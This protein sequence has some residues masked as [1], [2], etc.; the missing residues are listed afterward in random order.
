MRRFVMTAAVLAL[1]V[2]RADAD[3][4]LTF[5][6]ASSSTNS[7]NDTFG[8]SFTTTSAVTVA[9][10][11]YILPGAN[12][13]DVR[14]YNAAGTT[15]ASATV[16][17][18]DPTEST[19]GFTYNVHTLSLP[20][21]LDAKTTYYVAGDLTGG[22][23]NIPIFAQGVTTVTGISYGGGVL[24]IG[25]FGN[26][27]TDANVGSLNPAYFTVNFD[28]GTSVVST[29]EPSTI[30]LAISAIPVGLAVWARRR[31]RGD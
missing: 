11:D 1:M 8:F 26:P 5:T 17:S 13:G 20:L 10:L 31:K 22:H 12:G 15:L 30:A 16:L 6:R 28:L 19:G 14:L 25:S 29:P 27:T 9:A 18:T 23:D 2:G 24:Q 21:A 3:L 7:F 4:A